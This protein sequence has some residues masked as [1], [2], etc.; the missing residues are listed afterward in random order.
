MKKR[1]LCLLADGVE[2][3]ELIAPVD[4]LRRAGAEVIL[5]AVGEHLDVTTRNG[6]ILRGDALLE[7]VKAETF[8][9]LLLP[10]GPGVTRLRADGQ[11][12]LEVKKFANA[13]KG[14]AAICAAPLVL[15]D[16]GVLK[17]RQFTAHFST[18]SELPE[19]QLGE[20]VV[21]DGQLITARGAGVALEFGLA[22]VNSLFGEA[23][24]EEI[25]RSIMA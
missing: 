20:R 4:V 10:G 12:A 2:E 21:E 9:L 5:A 23:V 8:D 25:A 3:L 24:E 16:A 15:A 19:A 7:N 6:V 18:L 13:G 1:V 14:I 11:A 17:N 22:L